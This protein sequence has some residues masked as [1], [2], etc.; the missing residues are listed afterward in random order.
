MCRSPQLVEWFTGTGGGFL[1]Y[2]DLMAAF[3]P[4]VTVVMAHHIYHSIGEEQ[5]AG[6]PL[7][8]PDFSRYA[9]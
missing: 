2:L 4:V 5:A 3:W 1:L 9:A 6:D 7:E 8:P